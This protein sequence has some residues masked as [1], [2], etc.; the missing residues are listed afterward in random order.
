MIRKRSTI[1][2]HESDQKWD[3][4]KTRLCLCVFPLALAFIKK[5]HISSIFASTNRGTL[6]L[7]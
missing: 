6:P 3:K 1:L 2:L 5:M 4:G 7:C